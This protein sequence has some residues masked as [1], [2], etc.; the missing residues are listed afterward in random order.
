M[1]VIKRF[2]ADARAVV[3]VEDDIGGTVIYTNGR[4]SYY[5]LDGEWFQ[6]V[7][8]PAPDVKSGPP[9]STS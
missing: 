5:V 3:A 9:V 4:P 8:I 6:A 7:Q 2:E 1:N